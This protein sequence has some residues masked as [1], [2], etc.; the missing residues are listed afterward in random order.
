MDWPIFWLLSNCV[1]CSHLNASWN[2]VFRLLTHTWIGSNQQQI[3]YQKLVKFDVFSWQICFIFILPIS[4]ASPFV[5]CEVICS[6]V[7]KQHVRRLSGEMSRQ[8]I[9]F[10]N[11]YKCPCVRNFLETFWNFKMRTSRISQ[12]PKF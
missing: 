9:L 11:L 8:E 7:W 5:I 6:S 2:R 4:R 1:S 10:W 3:L 12:S